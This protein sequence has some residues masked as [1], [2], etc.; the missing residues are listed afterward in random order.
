[1]LKNKRL[2][3]GK[4]KLSSFNATNNSA[5]NNKAGK[6]IYFELKKNIRGAQE[7]ENKFR[8][9]TRN[10]LIDK[11]RNI[12]PELFD[13]KQTIDNNINYLKELIY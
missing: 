2:L 6:I 5:K 10:K 12:N 4:M 11:I 7:V 8:S 1:M 13:L 9:L 3:I